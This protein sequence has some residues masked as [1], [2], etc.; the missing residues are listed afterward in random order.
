MLD[1]LGCSHH[2]YFAIRHAHRTQQPSPWMLYS[3][4]TVSL[5][6]ASYALKH[7]LCISSARQLYTNTPAM[8]HELFWSRTTTIPS[9]HRSTIISGLRFSSQGLFWIPRG[10]AREVNEFH[11]RFRMCR[12]HAGAEGPLRRTQDSPFFRLFFCYPS[13]HRTFVSSLYSVT[14]LFSRTFIVFFCLVTSFSI[15]VRTNKISLLPGKPKLHPL[16]VSS[17][18]FKIELHI[19]FANCADWVSMK[20]HL[21]WCNYTRITM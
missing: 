19:L 3:F 10:T 9:A 5:H 14:E 8:K 6:L 7:R 18:L 17:L 1:M 16:R 4:Q 21:L 2:T 15:P 11:V 20:V 12:K 13:V